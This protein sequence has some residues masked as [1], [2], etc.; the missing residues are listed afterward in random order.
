[1]PCTRRKPIAF[2]T[3]VPTVSASFKQGMRMDN[4]SEAAFNAPEFPGRV[5]G[6]AGGFRRFVPVMDMRQYRRCGWFLPQSSPFVTARPA[7]EK[8][9]GAHTS[10]TYR[11][12]IETS[13]TRSAPSTRSDASAPGRT[14]STARQRAFESVQDTAG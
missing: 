14:P 2:L 7:L 6:S 8:H 5:I 1:M 9:A 11:D 3:H 4:S 13:D 12:E 10:G